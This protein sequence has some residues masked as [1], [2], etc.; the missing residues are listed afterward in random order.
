[1]FDS[2]AIGSRHKFKSTKAKWRCKS[3]IPPSFFS[4]CCAGDQEILF[5]HFYS[6][7][8]PLTLSLFFTPLVTFTKLTATPAC[9]ILYN[10]YLSTRLYFFVELVQEGVTCFV[11]A[12]TTGGSVAE[13]RDGRKLSQL[14]IAARSRYIIEYVYLAAVIDS[15]GC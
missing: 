2:T 9:C 5:Q 4:G 11:G 14:T 8:L 6:L 12:Q 10:V 13:P 15:T 1:M 3:K 7:P